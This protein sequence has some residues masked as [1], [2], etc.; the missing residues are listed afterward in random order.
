MKHSVVTV[1]G[2]A[3]FVGRYV[4][5]ALAQQGVQ[6]RVACRRPEEAMR[7]K[8]MGD[9]GQIAPVAANIRNAESV[10]AAVAGTDAV[11]NLVGV[12]YK[13]GKQNF[14]SLHVDGAHIVAAAAKAAGAEARGSNARTAETRSGIYK[15]HFT[16]A[17]GSTPQSSGARQ[18]FERI[19]DQEASRNDET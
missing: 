15:K 9:V 4:V 7:C 19:A 14:D 3:G 5:S 11:V 18:E 13:R 2:G 17:I 8:P 10:A 1:F 12:L 16:N 6:V